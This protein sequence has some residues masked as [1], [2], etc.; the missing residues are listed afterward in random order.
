ME[1]NADFCRFHDELRSLWHLEYLAHGRAVAHHVARFKKPVVRFIT[2]GDRAACIRML[3]DERCECALDGLRVI[4]E[5][6]VVANAAHH[7]FKFWA[8][9]E[10]QQRGEASLRGWVAPVYSFHQRWG[11]PDFFDDPHRLVDVRDLQADEVDL[12]AALAM[13]T[14][15]HGVLDPAP[16]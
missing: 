8:G 14:L 1:P 11:V 9:D 10:C 12:R 16:G 4:V 2:K 13:L 5:R 15:L 6:Q 7:L 3:S